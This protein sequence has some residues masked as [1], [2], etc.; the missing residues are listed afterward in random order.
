MSLTSTLGP[1]TSV[2]VGIALGSVFGAPAAR[3]AETSAES[4]V[5]SIYDRYQ[6]TDAKGTAL[7]TDAQVRLYFEPR[8]AA[9]ILGDRRRA[10]GE[11]GKLDGDPF[12]DAQDW[13][14]EKVDVAVRTIGSD[15]ATATVSFKN[16]GS[17]RTVTLD[18]VRLRAGWRI[19]DIAWDRNATLR[20]L[21]AGR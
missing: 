8:L 9:L 6:G 4:F 1:V 14:I 5:A 10:R 13:E 15:R 21:L 11:V 20:G 16:A 2:L 18:L 17:P 19:A 7:E 12:V 3:G